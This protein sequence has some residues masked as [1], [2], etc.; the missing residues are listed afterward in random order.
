MAPS[1]PIV[2]AQNRRENIN[3]NLSGAPVP[4][5]LL[6]RRLANRPLLT[7]HGHPTTAG[8]PVIQPFNTSQGGTIIS[9]GVEKPGDAAKIAG[10][11]LMAPVNPDRT[12]TNDL[13]DI[14]HKQIGDGYMTSQQPLEDI[15]NKMV[16][17]TQKFSPPAPKDGAVMIPENPG[18]AEPAVSTSNS[19]RE[20]PAGHVDANGF[21]H[22]A[23]CI[24]ALSLA[25]PVQSLNEDGS[26][27]AGG[28]E[29]WW[30]QG[31][32]YTREMEEDMMENY[33]QQWGCFE[34]E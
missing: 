17:E 30:N 6:Q 18:S 27:A 32:Y 14:Q 4:S 9:G 1:S 3:P 29:N 7:P 8:S 20:T 23:K 19:T 15:G 16:V 24:H 21:M 33:C 5:L 2:Q 26:D 34:Q 10:D 25:P 28:S 12:A 31:P 13:T 22:S 11:D